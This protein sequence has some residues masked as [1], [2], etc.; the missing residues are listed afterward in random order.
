ML[1]LHRLRARRRGR[2]FGS[3]VPLLA[4]HLRAVQWLHVPSY[5]AGLKAAAHTQ[6]FSGDDFAFA[7]NTTRPCLDSE[8]DGLQAAL[9]FGKQG[10]HSLPAP[11][12]PP[13]PVGSRMVPAS[14][15]GMETCRRYHRH[16][17]DWRPHQPS[18]GGLAARRDRR[19]HR[20]LV[21]ALPLNHK[22][23]SCISRMI[24]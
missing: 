22:S 18:E 11:R 8:S 21:V 14:S 15:L 20:R 7:R 12:C 17:S 2:Q 10:W 19:N 5:V 6:R 9:S 1:S 23:Q 4:A 16:T 3:N 24:V 13:R